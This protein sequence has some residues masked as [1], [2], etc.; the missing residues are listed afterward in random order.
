MTCLVICMSSSIARL[1]CISFEKKKATRGG[2]GGGR[3]VKMPNEVAPNVIFGND[4]EKAPR[5]S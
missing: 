2:G 5:K 4:L 1:Q 3:N